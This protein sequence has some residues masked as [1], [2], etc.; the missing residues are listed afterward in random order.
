MR[1]EMINDVGTINTANMTLME[2]IQMYVKIE[3]LSDS[4]KE[5]VEKAIIESKPSFE[6]R[7]KKMIEI[8]NLAWG[9]SGFKKEYQLE[10]TLNPDSTINYFLSVFYEDREY[11]DMCDTIQ[12]D[13][14][15]CH[16]E[17]FKG[18]AF[19]ALMEKFS[20]KCA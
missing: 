12:I 8:Y 5:D 14:P 4:L 11:E 20:F 7:Q 9:N 17:E 15:E 18:I 16:Y 13:L 1:R 10:F 19:N 2:S 3:S 6:E